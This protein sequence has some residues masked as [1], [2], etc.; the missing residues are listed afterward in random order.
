MSGEFLRI[1]E[2]VFNQ[3]VATN[4]LADSTDAEVPIF[5]TLG[6]AVT[7]G[8]SFE[9]APHIRLFNSVSPIMVSSSEEQPEYIKELA[10]LDWPIPQQPKQYKGVDL[11][12]A[13]QSYM[14]WI[15][16]GDYEDMPEGLKE[17]APYIEPVL[18]RKGM[19]FREALEYAM[20]TREYRKGDLRKQRLI[21]AQVNDEFMEMAWSELTSI[22]A[23]ERLGVAAL[24]IEILKEE[25]L[26]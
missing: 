1:V 10:R 14:T 26:R 21:I 18:N 16:K 13:Q 11:T 9:E 8:P 22:P 7:D 15:A 6:R 2:N 4:I 19:T 5:D 25:K 17:I 12:T 24:E 20:V 23:Y 3:G